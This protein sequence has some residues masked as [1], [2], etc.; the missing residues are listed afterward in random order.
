[1]AR[2]TKRHFCNHCGFK[3]AT[4]VW[5]EHMMGAVHAIAT[6]NGKWDRAIDTAERWKTSGQYRLVQ[7]G[8]TDISLELPNGIKIERA[9]VYAVDSEFT[10]TF[11]HEDGTTTTTGVNTKYTVTPLDAGCTI[12]E[13]S[14]PVKASSPTHM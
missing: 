9:L 6:K 5:S 2:P 8:W 4:K 7:L 11:M 13:C 1:M 3:V 12:P 10:L 14:P